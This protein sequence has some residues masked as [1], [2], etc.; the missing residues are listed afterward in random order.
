MN[1]LLVDKS[2]D[3]AERVRELLLSHGWNVDHCNDGLK[4]LDMFRHNTYEFVITEIHLPI[5]D[6][7][8]VCTLMKEFRPGTRIIFA[9]A[10]S[11]YRK[12]IQAFHAGADVFLLKPVYKLIDE[13]DRLWHQG[14]ALRSPKRLRIADLVLNLESGVVYRYGKKIDLQGKEFDLLMYMMLNE[15]KLLN[16]NTVL[17]HV[18]ED[19]IGSIS[20]NV[21]DVYVN[22]LRKKVDRDF[23]KKLI[24]T[25]HGVGY[26]LCTA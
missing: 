4:A 15:G 13:M 7:I 6:G 17:E 22:R 11:S 10:D 8:S 21:I 16:R 19:R 12:R 14:S 18:W 9:T 24:H 1:V 3:D 25:I 23:K 2:G 26:K 20:A 5:I